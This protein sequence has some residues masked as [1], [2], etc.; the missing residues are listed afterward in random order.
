[1][2]IPDQLSLFD[3]QQWRA[4]GTPGYYPTGLPPDWS[5]SQLHAWKQAIIQHQQAQAVTVQ[6]DFWNSLPLVNPFT[7][8]TESDRFF[9]FPQRFRQGDPCIYFVLDQA[10]PLVLYIGETVNSRRRWQ[11]HHDCKVYLRHYLDVHRRLGI[12]TRI[13]WA[14]YWEVPRATRPRQRLEQ[15][16]IRHWLPPFNKE[17]W[18]RWG[19]PW[20]IHYRVSRD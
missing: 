20:R 16:L 19:A 13:H 7:L 3:Q 8:G 10:A 12:P 15:A 9:R 18:S 1:M 11:G 14:F 2:S 4:M 5:P 6:G 17:S